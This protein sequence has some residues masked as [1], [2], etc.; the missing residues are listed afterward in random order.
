[1]FEHLEAEISEFCSMKLSIR[2]MS[3]LPSTIMLTFLLLQP[4]QIF[5]KHTF[6]FF[7]R[8]IHD[9]EGYLGFVVFLHI[10]FTVFL[11]QLSLGWMILR[12]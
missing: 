4:A 12:H 2:R 7:S 3:K 11:S 5:I 6:V 9:Y 1:M 8:T 10:M